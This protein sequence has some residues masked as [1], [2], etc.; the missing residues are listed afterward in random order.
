MVLRVSTGD[1]SLLAA[2][3]RHPR[4]SAVSDDGKSS[5]RFSVGDWHR[6]ISIG[7]PREEVTGLTELI[8][9]NPLVCADRFSLPSPAT[10][11]A[12]IALGPIILAGMLVAPPTL[13]TNL[14]WDAADL[15]AQL[16]E[17]GWQEGAVI[18]SQQD[19]SEVA[20]LTAFAEIKAPEDL[21]EIDEAFAERFGR[22]FFVREDD[23]S[24]WTPAAVAGSQ[25]ALYRLRITVDEPN[26]LLTVRVLADRNGKLGPGQIIHAMNVMCGFE[27]SLGV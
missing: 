25:L 18:Q 7:L 2:L 20:A 21:A 13:T 8:D 23:V 17:L 19:D 3:S 9:N 6:S 12:L 22:S 24:D 5:L 4:V 15:E 16:S 11:L 26:S 14:E 10:S 27:E 1:P